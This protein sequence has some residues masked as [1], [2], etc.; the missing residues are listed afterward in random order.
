M[1]K[2]TLLNLVGFGA[3]ALVALFAIPLIVEALGTDRF[4][5]LTLTWVLIGYLSLLDMGL[6]RA[7]TKLVAEKLGQ[8]AVEDIPAMIWTALSA[9]VLLSIGMS[10]LLGLFS[11]KI[12]Q[13]WLNIPLQLQGEAR[14]TFLMLTLFVPLV[15][16]SVGFRGVLEAYQRFD[17]VNAV[18]VPLGIFSFAAPLAVIPF[19]VNLVVVVA[20]LLV[21]R[22]LAVIVQFLFCLRIV[23]GL[24][25]GFGMQSAI[26]F[27]LLRFGSWM[28]LSNV[29]SPV[30]VYAD[31]FLIGAFLSVTAVAFYA[32]PSEAITQLTLISAALM[33]VMFPAFSSTFQ[34]DRLRSAHLM[35]RSLKYVFIV[36]F[37]IV[38]LVVAFAGELLTVWLNIEFA[39]TS[40]RVCQFLAVGVFFICLGQMPYALIQGAGRPDLTGRLHLCQLPLYIVLLVVVVRWAGINGAALLWAARAFIDMFF[41]YMMAQKLLGPDKLRTLP[42]AT[43]LFFALFLLCLF[44]VI[45]P[46]PVRIGGAVFTMALFGWFAVR[47]LL[48]RDEIAFLISIKK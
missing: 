37:P 12:V 4:G 5:I 30:L 43:L 8:G 9:M 27:R 29:I 44:A 26:F 47:Y 19:S 6:G 39:Q 32:T 23:S 35:D 28:T 42:K 31:R 41:M 21:V 36:L 17:L 15:M 16:A 34:V 11:G 24:L 22:L 46:L 10:L 40:F 18:R 25:S 33:G 45:A 7:L 14:A 1:A 2:N 48:S 3:P 13:E 38:F 20:A